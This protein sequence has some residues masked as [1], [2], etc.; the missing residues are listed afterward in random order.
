M[1]VLYDYQAFLQRYGGV[2]KYFVEILKYFPKEV[3][4][5]SV[6]LSDNQQLLEASELKD[7]WSLFGGKQ[8]FGKT[9]L[10]IYVNR[11]YTYYKMNQGKFDIFHPTLYN[12]YANK[13]LGKSKKMVVTIHD[14]NYFVIPELYS[15]LNVNKLPYNYQKEIIDRA[16]H[17]VSISENTRKDIIN[18]FG[19]DNSKI[20]TVY[21]GICSPIDLSNKDRIYSRKYILYVGTRALYKNF[22][23]CIKAFS[24]LVKKYDD[25]DLVCTGLPFS[26]KEMQMLDDYGVLNKV[27]LIGATEEQMALLYRD[28]EF[29]IYP[30]FYEGFG[31]PI[32]EAMLYKCP[33]V[34]SN[35]S[36][37]P[38]IAGNAGCYF[39]PYSVESILFAMEKILTD[40]D[41]RCDIIKKGCNRVKSFSWKKSA[42]EHMKIY[43]KII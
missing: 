42:E 30:S 1:K 16:D 17:I 4:D 23:G 40:T 21:H 31:M 11:L 15:D 2:P 7:V 3:Y 26:R 5:I 39:D 14:L 9:R 10:Y 12:P 18:I 22:N 33:V 28:A 8:F 41:Y 32:L 34:L 25:I 29:F 37:F 6:L 27:S 35:T 24:Y 38:E 19:V 20:T 13:I 36:C 43:N